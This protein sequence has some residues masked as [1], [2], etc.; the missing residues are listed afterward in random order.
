MPQAEH[1]VLHK[2]ALP[3]DTSCSSQGPRATLTSDQLAANAEVSLTLQVQWFPKTTHRAQEHTTLTIRFIRA[4][5]LKSEPAKR[6][7]P[8][9][10]VWEGPKHEASGYLPPAESG[11]S[12]SPRGD[13]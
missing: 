12:P 3:L 5:G 13:M 4:K 1:L 11:A 7:D 6:R 8:G 10:Q 9:G 2:T